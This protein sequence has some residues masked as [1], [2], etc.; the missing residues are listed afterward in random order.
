MAVLAVEL[1][2][3]EPRCVHMLHMKHK[4]ARGYTVQ[5]VKSKD[6]TGKDNDEKYCSQTH[7]QE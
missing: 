4:Q 7:P 5:D 3:D 6:S 2:S 1:I